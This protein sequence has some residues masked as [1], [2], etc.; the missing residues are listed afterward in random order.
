MHWIIVLLNKITIFTYLSHFLGGTIWFPHPVG[1][2]KREKN[3]P[4][5]PLKG[6]ATTWRA[7]LPPSISKKKMLCFPFRKKKS[8]NSIPRRCHGGGQV[9]FWTP[10]PP[11]WPRFLTVLRASTT[12]KARC[13]RK[14]WEPLFLRGRAKNFPRTFSFSSEDPPKI[15]WWRR[16]YARINKI[17]NW[18]RL[19]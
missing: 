18:F 6:Q 9:C 13:R 7:V 19:V 4:G 2:K 14:I 8:A 11:L 1:D 5:R 17:G 10:S 15:F 12:K 16:M 3:L